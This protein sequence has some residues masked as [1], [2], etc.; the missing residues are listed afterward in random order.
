[1]GE[2]L[3]LLTVSQVKKPEMPMST[4]DSSI[5]LTEFL[6]QFVQMFFHPWSCM[7]RALLEWR[8]ERKFMRNLMRKGEKKS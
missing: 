6:P 8:K 3:I 1:M 7:V 2:G 5:Q 4:M